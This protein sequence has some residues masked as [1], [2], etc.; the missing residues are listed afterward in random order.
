[1][2]F[3]RHPRLRYISAFALH[4]EAPFGAVH[5][6]VFQMSR[7]APTVLILG[8]SFVKRLKRDLQSQ[9]NT[10]AHESFGLQGIVSV[11]GVQ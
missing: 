10:R 2:L 11:E 5:L 7:M 9:F 3:C 4:T 6:F 1:M 8:H